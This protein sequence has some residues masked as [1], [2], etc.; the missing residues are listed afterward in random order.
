[1]LE[2]KVCG[3]SAEVVYRGETEGVDDDG[4]LAVL[5]KLKM[6]C[7]VGHRYDEVGAVMRY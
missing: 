7:E 4:K 1:M 2:C 5:E 3:A 6:E